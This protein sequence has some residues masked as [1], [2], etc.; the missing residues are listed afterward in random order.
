MKPFLNKTIRINFGDETRIANALQEVA[1]LYGDVNI[2]SYPVTNQ[3][4]GAQILVTLD[5]KLSEPLEKAAE[6][7]CHR[8]PQDSILEVEENVRSLLRSSSSVL[9]SSPT[10]PGA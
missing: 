4:D 10:R 9:V 8:L 7:L 5:G 6:L 3:H 1:N 2:G